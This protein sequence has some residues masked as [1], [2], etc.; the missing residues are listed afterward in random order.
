MK[1]LTG[2]ILGSVLGFAVGYFGHCASGTCPLTGNPWVST[3]V[4]AVSGALIAGK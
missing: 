2:I 4:G 3:M 1:I